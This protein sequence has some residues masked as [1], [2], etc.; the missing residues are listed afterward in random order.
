MICTL[1]LI[2]WGQSFQLGFYK[3]CYYDCG[4][5]R[6]GYY[7]RVYKVDPDYYCPVRLRLA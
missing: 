3:V 7:D 6:F 2:A 4:L 5:R 1:V